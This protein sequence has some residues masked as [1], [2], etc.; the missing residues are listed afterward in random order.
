MRFQ[1]PGWH[2]SLGVVHSSAWTV[3]TRGQH[4]A[5]KP[6]VGSACKDLIVHDECI[7]HA[8]A[9]APV[10]HAMADCTLTLASCHKVMIISCTRK[11]LARAC[12]HSCSMFAELVHLQLLKAHV[13]GCQT[14][15]GIAA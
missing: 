10:P 14:S 8:T 2:A 1:N 7:V 15:A 3:S 5:S 4:S 13:D 12:T 11:C 6:R 9:L